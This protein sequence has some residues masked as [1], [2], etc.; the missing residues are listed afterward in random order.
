MISIT[1]PDGSKR[2]FAAPVTVLQLAE[3]IGPGL[4]KAALAGK[5]DGKTVDTSHLIANAV[6]NLFPAA[7]VTIGPVIENGFYY[8]FAFERAFTPEDLAAIEKEMERLAAADI[9]VQ[10][11]LMNRSE[12]VAMF[13]GMGEQ[14]KVEI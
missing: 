8:D 12:A 2:E 1:L 5:V 14:Y 6:K 4:A 7:Q 3:A 10:R 9:P 13:N 11:S